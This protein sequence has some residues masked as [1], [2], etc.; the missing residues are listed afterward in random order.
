MHGF[1]LGVAELAVI[2]IFGIPLAAI[3][4]SFLLA[5]LKILKGNSNVRMYAEESRLVQ[6][7]HH[8]L[9]R[10]EQRVNALETI[11]LDRERMRGDRE[12]K[13]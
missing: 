13:L 5:A 9:Q 10:M 11:L 1:R 8:S 2:L 12:G 7:I 4:G 3:L 6:E